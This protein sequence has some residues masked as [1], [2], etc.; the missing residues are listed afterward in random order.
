MR[1][2]LETIRFGRNVP[3][4]MDPLILISLACAMRKTTW[5]PPPIEV[6]DDGNG[7]VVADGR[8]RVMAAYIAGRTRIDAIY[9]TE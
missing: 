1:I 7:Y 2:P 3:A 4:G 6:T 8:H 5:E 9:A